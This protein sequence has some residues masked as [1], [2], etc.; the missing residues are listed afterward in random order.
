MRQAMK[1]ETPDGGGNA[2]KEGSGKPWLVTC[3]TTDMRWYGDVADIKAE[4]R[5]RLEGPGNAY[6][7]GAVTFGDVT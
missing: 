5:R 2:I 6:E 1:I 7:A 4:L 3:P